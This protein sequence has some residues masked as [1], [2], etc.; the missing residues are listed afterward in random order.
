MIKGLSCKGLGIP[1][2]SPMTVNVQ[3]CANLQ[4]VGLICLFGSIG[5]AT[6][7]VGVFTMDASILFR[8]MLKLHFVSLN[9]DLNCL[10]SQS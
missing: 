3:P 7:L 4:I 8:M 9:F 1:K 5:S 2:T 6:R 10:L